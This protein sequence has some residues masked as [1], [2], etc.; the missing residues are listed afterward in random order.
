MVFS[1]SYQRESG[2]DLLGLMRQILRQDPRPPSQ[3][4]DGRAFGMILWD[5]NIRW[6][7][8]QEGFYVVSCERVTAG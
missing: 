5:V 2:R 7:V 6:Q 1:L 3:K 8:R 4:E